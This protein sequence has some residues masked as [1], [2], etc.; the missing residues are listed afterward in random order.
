MPLSRADSPSATEVL[1]LVIW[2][3][4]GRPRWDPAGTGKVTGGFVLLSVSLTGEESEPRGNG[5]LTAFGHAQEGWRLSR[6]SEHRSDA[7]TSRGN[8]PAHR[9]PGPKRPGQQIRI[10][11]LCGHALLFKATLLRRQA[12]RNG[13]SATDLSLPRQGQLG[14][15]AQ[16]EPNSHP[17]RHAARPEQKAR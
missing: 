5:E 8:P 7:S 14:G 6:R 9:T 16:L 10:W 17:S 2:A 13:A 3:P 4:S 12:L 1:E 11:L 15:A